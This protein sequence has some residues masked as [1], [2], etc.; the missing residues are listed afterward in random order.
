MNAKQVDEFLAEHCQNNKTQSNDG[1]VDPAIAWVEFRN[2]L[3]VRSRKC[4]IRLNIHTVDSLI[5]HSGEDLLECKNFGITSLN[6]VREKLD[7]K[8]LKLRGD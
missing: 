1:E 4:M 2:G 8:G 5:Q 3:S 7:E 6:E